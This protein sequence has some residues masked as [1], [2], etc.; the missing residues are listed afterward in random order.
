MGYS[1]EHLWYLLMH[2]T[3][4]LDPIKIGVCDFGDRLGYSLTYGPIPDAYESANRYE[5]RYAT[6]FEQFTA[7]AERAAPRI[8]EASAFHGVACTIRW[9]HISWSVT[10]ERHGHAPLKIGALEK[11]FTRNREFLNLECLITAAEWA[12]SLVQEGMLFDIAK[13]ALLL[14]PYN[15]AR[16]CAAQCRWRTDARMRES[17]KRLA[18][19]LGLHVDVA[20]ELL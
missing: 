7:E 10:L 15:L 3:D 9:R 5:E 20:I 6:L 1:N 12:P 14:T 8:V 11:G 2:G 13:Y 18:D 16:L 4:K 19:M 17:A